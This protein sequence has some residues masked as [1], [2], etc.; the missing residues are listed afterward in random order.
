MKSRVG[1][2]AVEGVD[3]Q[4]ASQLTWLRWASRSLGKR[5]GCDFA[6]RMLLEAAMA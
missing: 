6:R 5:K 4:Q 2:Q 3:A 1:A